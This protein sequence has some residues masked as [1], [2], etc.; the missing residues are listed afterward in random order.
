MPVS[1]VLDTNVLLHD[2]K[3]I[4]FFEEH[5]VVVPLPAIR[6][7]DKFKRDS[8]ELGANARR[9]SRYIEKLGQRGDLLTGVP[10]TGGGTFRVAHCI[11]GPDETVDDAII[12]CAAQ[13][14]D[15]K[16]V[17]RDTNMRIIAR[18][19]GVACEDY[20]HDRAPEVHGQYR[21]W[22]E[23]D[24]GLGTVDRTYDLL[25]GGPTPY[26]SSF[27]YDVVGDVSPNEFLHLRSSSSSL[28]AR[29]N[30]AGDLVGVSSDGVSSLS[31]KSREQVFA[32]NLLMDPSVPLVT[33]SGVAGTGKTLLALA[34]GLGQMLNP[35]IYTKLMVSRPVVP[36]G[37]GVG[38]LPGTLAEKMDP[39]MGPIYDNLD[40]LMTSKKKKKESKPWE[41]L[42]Q[43]G[44]LEV[45]A[46]S[47]IRGR[48][49]PELY[50]V[51]DEAQNLTPHEV[52]T[53]LTRAGKGTKVILTGD[54]NQIDNPYV[55]AR[56]NGLSYVTEKFKGSPLAGHVTLS[57]GERSDLAEEAARIL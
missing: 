42:I 4:F 31:P 14:S 21:G 19:S 51:I 29:V 1:Y 22:R 28:L 39:W 8:T 23:V 55:D 10:L 33:L 57:K 43:Q 35:A 2:P 15:A 45:E 34:A 56:T 11:V 13:L 7:I 37:K 18:C 25:R 20:R 52:K 49:I 48:S 12:H 17:T 40:F 54:P 30:G 32:L 9:V 3:S 38:F 53:V 27:L 36:M 50:M 5:Q 26:K 41:A 6:E 16:L 44:L 47:F 24:T 46:L